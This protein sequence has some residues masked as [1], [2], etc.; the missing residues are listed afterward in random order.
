MTAIHSSAAFLAG[1]IVWAVTL[2]HALGAPQLSAPV[3]LPG[4]SALSP[5]AGNQTNAVLARGGDQILMVWEDTRASLAGTQTAQGY[6]TTVSDVYAARLDAGGNPIDIEPIPVAT[7]AFSQT[8]PKV[9]WNGSHWLVVW[10]SRTPSQYTTTAWTQQEPGLVRTLPGLQS[11]VPTGRKGG[12]RCPG[13]RYPS[14]T[15]CRRWS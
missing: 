2:P 1:W 12:H 11:T 5:P 9:A 10:T 13:S 14:R 3:V 7:G 15:T 4:D 8:L 6:G